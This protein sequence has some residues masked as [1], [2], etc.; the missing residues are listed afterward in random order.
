MNV[1]KQLIFLI[2]QTLANVT[3]AATWENLQ[4]QTIAENVIWKSVLALTIVT[5]GHAY[6]AKETSKIVWMFGLM[7]IVINLLENAGKIVKENTSSAGKNAKVLKEMLIRA[8][9]TNAIWKLI[10]ATL[11]K[12]TLTTLVGQTYA[13]VIEVTTQDNLKNMMIADNAIRKSALAKMF[14]IGG[15]ALT[16]KEL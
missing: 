15:H 16:A 8:A 2:G 13:N 7:K 1:K 12:R 4:K 11:V 3:E 14:A 9:K 6:T 5:G 10:C